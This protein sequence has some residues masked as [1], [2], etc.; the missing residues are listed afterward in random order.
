M[1]M[2]G[3]VVPSAVSDLRTTAHDKGHSLVLISIDGEVAG[4]IELAPTIRP[5]ARQIIDSLHARGLSLYIISGDQEQPTRH[6]AEALGIEHY[7]ANTLP[8]HKAALIQQLQNE[9][10]R[11]CFVGDGINDAIALKQADLSISL[12]GAST[13]ATDTAQI[14]LMDATLGEL[15]GL[16]DLADAY[17][18]NMRANHVASMVPGMVVI[19]GVFLLHFGVITSIMF[20]NVGLIA[21]V[22]NAMSPILRTGQPQQKFLPN[23]ETPV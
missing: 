14:V 22:A 13:I 9:G 2:E 10:K 21:G 19:G 12:R 23:K 11:V 15:T 3:V 6:L 8:E 20:Y 5:E 4:A 17:D 7:F 16:F 18:A 1:Q